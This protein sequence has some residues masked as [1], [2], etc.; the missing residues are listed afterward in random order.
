MKTCSVVLTFEYVDQIP[1]CNHTNE[2]S[3][4]VLLQGNICFSTFYKIKFR[5][6]LNFM[7]DLYS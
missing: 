2:F 7:N 4:A 1:Q 6:F 3:L 5:F